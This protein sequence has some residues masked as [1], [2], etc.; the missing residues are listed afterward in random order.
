LAWENFTMTV[1]GQELLAQ[2]V[3]QELKEHGFV[4]P[5]WQ[6]M[7]EHP[8][9]LGW[10]MGGGEWHLMMFWDWWESLELDE[11]SR[12]AW[13]RRWKPTPCWYPWSARLIWP[14]LLDDV[15]DDTTVVE[16]LSTL[17]IGSVQEWQDAEQKVLDDL[18][19]SNEDSSPET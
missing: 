9:S 1:S 8:Y 13:V 14:E 12:I 15:D 4:R 10:R 17:G 19:A 3:A 16:K 7:D 5:P 18:E 2:H 6:Y 11:S